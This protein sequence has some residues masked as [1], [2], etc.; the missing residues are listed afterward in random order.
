MK[1]IKM[2]IPY[3]KNGKVPTSN[4]IQVYKKSLHKYKCSYIL[5]IKYERIKYLLVTGTSALLDELNGEKLDDNSKLCLLSHENRLVLNKYLDFTVPQAFG[6]D[7]TTIGLGDRLGLATPGHIKAIQSTNVRPIFAQQS[8]R[9][10]NL[11]HRKMEDVIDDAAF[12]V[13]QEGYTKGYGAD[14]DHLKDEKDIHHE[15]T[16]GISMLTL[17]C[18]DYIPN[19]INTNKLSSVES[20]YENISSKFKTYYEKKYLDKT[21]YIKN[22]ALTFDAFALKRAVVIYHHAIQYMI[23]IY[24]NY[25]STLNR[26]IDFE[27]SIDETMTITSPFDHFFVANELHFNNVNITGLAPRFC[28]EFQKGIDYI[29]DINKFEKEL[30]AHALIADYFSYK[31]SIHSGSDKFSVFPFISQHTNNRF[32]LK[33]A[34]TSWL[35]ALRLISIYEPRLFKDL[36]NYSLK[37]FSD[38]QKYYH[39]T[40]DLN[41]I[42]SIHDMKETNYAA[43]LNDDNARQLLHVSFGLLLTAKDENNS[44]LFKNKIYSVLENHEIKYKKLLNNHMAQ[45]LKL[46]NVI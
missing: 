3:L 22:N 14:G 30:N 43:Y 10:L 39:I 38:T 37:Y 28:G 26:T 13:I 20:A 8:I 5:M 1:Q 15:L 32:H 9:E 19:D 41:A 44:L 21:F 25:I 7:Q 6:K 31:L 45:H 2:L 11:T 46:L 42:V 17:D 18:S 33:T 24:K 27:I 35:E 12:A 36:Y 34:G 16:L 4:H 29:G 23:H 40:P